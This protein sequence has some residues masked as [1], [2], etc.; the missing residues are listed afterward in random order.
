MGIGHAQEYEFSVQYR[1]GSLNAAADALSRRYSL[2]HCA[3]TSTV[4]T[5]N[6]NLRQQQLNDPVLKQLHVALTTSHQKP[7]SQ[8]WNKQP[9]CC[10]KQIWHQ[11]KLLDG[12]VCREYATGPMVE[13]KVVTICPTTCPTTL[14][15]ELLRRNHDAPSAGHQGPEKTLQR[16]RQEVYW[17]NMAR[18]AV[19]SIV[20]FFKCCSRCPITEI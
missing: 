9:L 14:R 19:C 15:Q 4:I 10:Y 6:K 5:E 11:L 3:L 13:T 17:V 18:D 20:R 1:K 16:L 12:I 8:Q 2:D 7:V